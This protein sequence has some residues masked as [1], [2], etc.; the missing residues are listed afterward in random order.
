MNIHIRICTHINIHIR[1]HIHISSSNDKGATVRIIRLFMQRAI[2]FRQCT[3]LCTSDISYLGSYGKMLPWLIVHLRMNMFDGVCV[4]NWH[5]KRMEREMMEERKRGFISDHSAIKCSSMQC[6]AQTHT[7]RIVC[8]G[9][10]G[11]H[12]NL[13]Y[14]QAF[15]CLCS[16][17][18]KICC[19]CCCSSCKTRCVCSMRNCV[20]FL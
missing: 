11:W 10:D 14:K 16:F 20:V 12:H 17:C 5:T 7:G 3:N 6:N 4:P 2:R 9:S 15:V 1:I 18:S 8:S 19:C 13:L